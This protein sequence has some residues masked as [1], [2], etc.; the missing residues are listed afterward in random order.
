[1]KLYEVIM[2]YKEPVQ[3]LITVKADSEEQAVQRVQ[4]ALPE[5]FEFTIDDIQESQE[6][7]FDTETVEEAAESLTNETTTRTVH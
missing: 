2:S 3:V 1:L 5:N 7:V 6:E 4:E